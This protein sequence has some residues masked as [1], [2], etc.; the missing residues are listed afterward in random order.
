M[1]VSLKDHL[2]SFLATH[3][4]RELPLTDMR[5]AA[6]LLPLIWNQTEYSLLFT[7]RTN[8]VEHHKGQISFPGGMVDENDND[9]TATALRE[10]FEEVGIPASAVKVLGMLDDLWVPS[11]FIIT[12]VVG[13]LQT[14][15]SL[16]LNTTE[17]AETFYVP[18][19]FFMNERHVRMEHRE[20]GGKIHEVYF[21]DYEQRTIWGATAAI[22]RNLVQIINKCL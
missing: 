13:F 10:I 4:R 3:Q 19:S 22:V 20:R 17:V 15:P 16:H 11:G 21:Y 1:N 5:S 12:P 8:T 14:L 18:L 9:V 6:V 7:E 2:K